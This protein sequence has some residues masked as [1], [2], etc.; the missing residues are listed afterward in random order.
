MRIER[1]G[2]CG[3]R[4]GGPSWLEAPTPDPRP[5]I[6][7][8]HRQLEARGIE[9]L[10]L[11]VPTKAMARSG[12]LVPSAESGGPWL[13]NPSFGA[14][15]DDLERAGIQVVDAT[16]MAA[17]LEAAGTASF[18][19]TD[20]H[21]SPELVDAVARVVA[22]GIDEGL[23]FEAPRR[24]WRE[25]S[26]SVVGTGDLVRLLEWPG[27]W[28]DE[29]EVR[30]RKVAT[31]DGRPW[32]AD[33]RAEILLLGDSFSNVF[34]TADLGWG[35]AAGLGERLSFHLGRTLDR[36]AV[37]DGSATAVRERW[38]TSLASEGRDLESLRLVIYQVAVRELSSG[39]WRRV[40]LEPA[41]Q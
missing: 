6:L 31:F 20:S 13:H 39:D 12:S 32:Q 7:D 35:S 27:S 26:E 30:L 18:L 1:A 36:I 15:R 25:A 11:A 34:S 24:A 38:A 21:W 37:N 5:A 23:S 8:L 29:E 22:A 16:E 14:F 19:R 28:P 3:I 2:R 9:L 10:F 17:E 4:R 41:S 40:V 33:P